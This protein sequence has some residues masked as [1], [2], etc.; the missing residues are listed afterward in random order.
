MAHDGWVE[1][2]RA[3]RVPIAGL[4]ECL[5]AGISPCDLDVAAVR[6]SLAELS[7]YDHLI[8]LSCGGSR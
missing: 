6:S 8:R 2:A 3:A 5:A 7:T 1:A 4:D